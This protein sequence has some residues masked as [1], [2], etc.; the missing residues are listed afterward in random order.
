MNTKYKVTLIVPDPTVPGGVAT[1]DIWADDVIFADLDLDN[2]IDDLPDG[3]SI[4][5]VNP[6]LVYAATVYK[7]EAD[8]VEPEV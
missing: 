4:A 6:N 2:V 3:D 5:Y 1:T 7:R 8:E